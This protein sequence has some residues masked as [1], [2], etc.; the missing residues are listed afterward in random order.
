MANPSKDKWTW[1]TG[2]R[3]TA[4]A[5]VRITPGSGVIEVNDKPLDVYFTEYKHQADVLAPLRATGAYGK[6][7]VFVN[8]TGGG[9]SGQSGAVKYWC[10]RSW[11]P[12]YKTT[13]VPLGA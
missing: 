1:G 13:L 3:K 9:I 11:S 12:R 10:R 8:A 5:R 7:D 2:R 6:I 4:V